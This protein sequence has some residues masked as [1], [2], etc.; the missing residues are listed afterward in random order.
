MHLISSYILAVLLAVVPQFEKRQNP[1]SL[2]YLFEVFVNV[3]PSQ[4]N[5]TQYFQLCVCSIFDFVCAHQVVCREANFFTHK[6]CTEHFY[7]PSIKI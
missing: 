6:G 3:K 5:D 4:K 7:G 2:L 1:L